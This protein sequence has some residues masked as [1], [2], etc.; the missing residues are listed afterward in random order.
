MS[1]DAALERAIARRTD[2]IERRVT[3]R[4]T[5]SLERAIET[6]GGDLRSA[7]R[8]EVR[9]ALRDRDDGAPTDEGA[10]LAAF[11]D[12]TRRRLMGDDD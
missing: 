12:E 5:R 7:I 1:L 3:A 11:A 6:F 9:L 10:E 4:V 8:R 2:E